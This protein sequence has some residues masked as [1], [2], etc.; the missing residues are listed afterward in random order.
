[1][2]LFEIVLNLLQIFYV[3]IRKEME[4]IKREKNMYSAMG[5][6]GPCLVQA[7]PGPRFNEMI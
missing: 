7:G 1:L 3:K 5:R 6:R 2:N 4:R